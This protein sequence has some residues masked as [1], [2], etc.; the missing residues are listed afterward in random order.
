M[1]RRKKHLQNPIDFYNTC[2]L[3]MSWAFN[4]SGITIP[5]LPTTYQGSN[6]KNYILS[7]VAMKQFI[8][9]TFGAYT[10]SIPGSA[11]GVKGENFP[12]LLAGKKGIYVMIPNDP[13]PYGFH[14]SGHVDIIEN[15]RCDGGCYF[16]GFPGG[17]KY[18][19]FWE[20]Q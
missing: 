16:G 4:N 15:G 11:G 1:L 5:L 12:A 6:S 13:G 14:A 18:I 20:L 10:D 2:A 9:K 8:K 3:R 7:A 17:V 19:L